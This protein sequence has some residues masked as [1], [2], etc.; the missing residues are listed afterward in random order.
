MMHVVD[1]KNLEENKNLI[2]G[3]IGYE[4]ALRDTQIRSIHEMGGIEENTGVAS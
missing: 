1:M 3:K 4:K 2:T